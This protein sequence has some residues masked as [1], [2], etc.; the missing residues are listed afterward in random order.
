MIDLVLATDMK[1]HFALLS[2]FNSV[3][4]S[5]EA[6]R[7]HQSDQPGSLHP[8]DENERVLSLQIAIKAADLANL[9]DPHDTHIKWVDMLEEEV[10][11]TRHCLSLAGWPCIQQRSWVE[12][13]L[14]NRAFASR[15]SFSK[16]TWNVR[17][18]CPSPRCLTAPSR[19][20]ASHR[21]RSWTWLLC[22]CTAH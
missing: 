11:G 5:P 7:K 17:R 15:S 18:G 20:S 21:W 10:G 1:Q 13:E 9:C 19:G 2:Q 3:H 16:V 12:L 6:A 14:L 4:A 22:R 8:L